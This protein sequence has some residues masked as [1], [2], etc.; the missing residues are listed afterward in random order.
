MPVDYRLFA[1][2]N[3]LGLARFGFEINTILYD[4]KLN[5]QLDENIFDK[6]IVTVLPDADKK[7]SSFWQNIQTIPNTT[8]E[9]IAYLRIDS[10]KNVP[11]TFWD[12]FS[13][14]SPRMQLN[15]NLSVSAP[16]SMYHFNPVE[17]HALDYGFFIDD[18]VEERLNSSLN[19]SYGFANKKL[20][21]DF[22]IQYLLGNYRTTELNFG[23]FN[24]T[25]ILF[26]E[27]DN[28][29]ELTSTLLALLSKYSFRDYYYSKGFSLGFYD[30]V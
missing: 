20:K 21:T 26:G 11:Q 10:L 23:T 22:L 5:D 19:F 14:L 24:K 1:N 29:N 16:I 15:D 8:E 2:A 28:Y 4:Y 17:G 7:D 3:Y 12:N 25:K 13:I 18:L 27:S 6:A 30:W 9:E